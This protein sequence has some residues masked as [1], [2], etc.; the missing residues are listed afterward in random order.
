[1]RDADL[2]CRRQHHL[3]VMGM[4]KD[5]LLAPRAATASGM[6]EG[7]VEVEGMGTVRVRGLS[8]GEVFGVQQRGDTASS[9]RL[10]LA[11]GMVEPELTEREVGQ[12][13]TVSPAGEIEPVVNK[14][15]ELSGLAKGSEKEAVVSFRDD[16]GPGVRVL[17]GD[18][19]GN[20]GGPAPGADEQ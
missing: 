16:A 6:P 20:D 18:E 11:C 17:P 14:I 13:Q 1:M 4:D 10:I 15:Q 19:A 7:T 9:E 5:K 2:G 3:G 8:R 12:W